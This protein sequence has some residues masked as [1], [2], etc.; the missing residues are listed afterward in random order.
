MSSRSIRSRPAIAVVAVA[1]LLAGSTVAP[2]YAAAPKTSSAAGKDVSVTLITG[3]RVTLVGGDPTKATIDP[4]AGRQHVGFN[5]YRTKD[6]SYIIPADVTKAVG[7]GKIDR[8][9]FDVAELVKDGYDDA[10]TST[11]PVL[12]TYAGT[13]KRAVPA[14]TRVTRQLPSIGGAAMKVNKSDAR[15]FIGSGGFSKLWLDGKRKVLLDQSVPQIGGPVAWQAGYTGKGVSVAVLDTG[16]DA[17]HPDLA[18]QVVGEKNF[19]TESA[20]DL[21]G[22]GTHVASTIAG[23]GAASDGRYKGVAPDARIYDGKV[24]EVWGCDESAILAGMDWAATDVKAKIVNLSLGGQDTP[25]VDPLEEA[26]NRLTAQTGTLFVIAAGNE[27][28]GESTVASPGSADAALTVGNVTKQDEL[29]STSSRGPRIGDSAVKPDVTAPGTDIVAAKSKDSSIGEPVGDKYLRLSGTSMATPHTAGAA[30]ILLQEHPSWTPADVKDALMGSAKV[31]ANQTSFQQGAGRIDLTTAIKQSVVASGSVSFG[32][33]SY[34]HTDDQPVTRD[35][36]FRNLG[37]AAVTL[38][39]T[40]MLS[41]PNGAAAP[42]GALKLSVDSVTVPAGGTASVQ[43]TSD[44]SLGGVDGLYSGRITATGGGQTVVVPVGVDKEGPTYT[45]TVKL[46]KPNGAPDPDYPLLLVGVDNDA[47]G[48]YAPDETGT[49]SIRLPQ[50]EYLLEQFQEFERAPEDWIFFKLAAPSVKLTADQ[51]VVLDARQAKVVTT[52]IPGTTAVQANADIGY[53]RAIETGN[54]SSGSSGFLSG[55]M[56]TYST[57]PKLPASAITGHVTSQWGVPGEDGLFTNTPYLYGIANYQPGEFVTGF[58]R[59]VKQ[60]DLAVVDSTVNAT[61]GARVF[62]MIAPQHPGADGVFARVIRLDVPRT[63]RYYLDET[64]GGWSG[65]TQQDTDDSP[66][67]IWQ[68]ELDGAPVIYKRGHHYQERWNAAVFAPSVYAATRSADAL[69]ISLYSLSDA[70]GH[71]GFIAMKSASTKLYRDGTEVG[72]SD[73]LGVSVT[74]QPAG[75]ASYKLVTT[76]TQEIW[77]FST[78]M[79]LEANFTSSADQPSIP[80]HTVSYQPDVDGNNTMLRKPVTV[81]PFTVAGVKKVQIQYSGDGG[82]TW[83]QAPVAGNKAIFPTPAGKAISLRSTATDAAGN[84]TT[85]TIITAY[86]MR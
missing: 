16:I 23:T 1:G 70:D 53:D 76:G 74:G 35:V 51:T 32:K 19:T 6:H 42:A 37:D 56:Y 29:N 58:D 59:R 9:L 68:W 7:D 11:I 49:V 67:P 54:F 33:A 10:S 77:P 81:L 31:A 44:T 38:S 30:A 75:K 8:R 47:F 43:A 15:A 71:N 18:T 52:S 62:K 36:T 69:D 61:D 48:N 82:A 78:R 80:I 12:T 27:G 72:S 55:S 73:G 2:A 46:I 21:V 26:V 20:D 45:L 28:P 65:I 63:I 25:D 64:A 66:L 86:T 4:G 17:T 5:T 60:S 79:D 22:H 85:Q 34:P 24:C 14:G 83:K 50:G 13:A 57:G 39:L 3:D 40:S 84:S 41:G